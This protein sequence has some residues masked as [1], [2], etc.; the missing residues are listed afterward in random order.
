MWPRTLSTSLA[1]FTLGLAVLSSSGCGGAQAR[2]AKHLQKGR[3][4]LAEG[5]LEKARVELRNALQIA[6]KDADA[7]FEMGVVAE[8]L[9][10]Q[11]E[12]AQYY[13][14]TIDVAPEHIGARAQLARLYLFS[15]APDRA[16]DLIKPV[17]DKHPEE[18]ELLTVR[19]A[20]HV[21]HKDLSA[22]QAD[23]E[24]AVQLASTSENAVAVLAG[25][26]TSQ[27][28]TAKA[29][30]LLERSIQKIPATVD[31]RLV[32]AQIYAQQSRPADA[33]AL[34]IKLVELKPAEKAHRLRLAQ[35]YLQSNQIDAAER[36]MRQAVS[37][38]P[39]DRDLKLSLIDFLAARRS[40]DTAEKELQKMIAAAPKDSVLKFA[41]A[42]FYLEGQDSAH[43]EAVYRGVIESE[44]LDP[45]GLS[46]RD[47]LAALRWQANDVKGALA[48]AEEVLAKSPRDDDAL[49]LRGNIALSKQDPR[50][51]I[52]DLRA[53][54]RDQPNAIGVLRS[55]ARA[56]LANGEPAVAEEVMRHA[57]EANPKNAALE[58]DFAQL[59]AQLGKAEQAKPIVTEMVKQS[60][61]NI[62]ALSTEF[63]I[64]LATKDFVMAKSAADG[65]VAIQP[66]LA[67]GYLYQ[68]TVAEHDGR[69]D[70]ALNLYLKAADLQPDAAEPMEAEV[71]L[72]VR[73]KR[74]AEAVRRLDDVAARFPGNSLALNLKGNLFLSDGRI[75]EARDTFN[76]AIARTP[77]WWPPY[78]GL[79]YAQLA[80]KDSA[81]AITTLRNAKA[82]VSQRDAL[83]QELAGLLERQGKQDEA[84]AE[85]EEIV[86]GYPQS[87][88][89]ANNLAM[90]LA[91]YKK[92]PKSLE[93]AK[94]LSA[95]FADS[96]NPSFLDTYGWVLFKRGDAAASVPVL[97]RVV[98]KVPDAAMARYHLGMAQALAGDNSDARD[99]LTRALNSGTQF[100]GLDEAKS[101]LDKL[102]KIPATASVPKS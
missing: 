36:T 78:R 93:R 34:L 64:G 88:I 79:A 85:Y 99:N 91:T 96:S 30:A 70:E 97:M 65:I 82:V 48:L 90:L 60:P 47:R 22:A 4:F 87:E 31:L 100:S 95:R 73:A 49:I 39:S 45:A 75:A 67:V 29:Q 92:D 12:A 54:L 5:N 51:A 80:A 9:G 89:A 94:E 43:A 53:V 61:D 16:L 14:G 101:T 66:K 13:Q 57:V 86:R 72:L 37:D 28:D 83:G 63:R 59:L 15:G 40:R 26:Y 8:K 2:E 71:R 25:V 24:R 21:Q 23:A 102:T 27:S 38:L 41:L 20:I 33:E 32:L 42:K 52:A 74:T 46:A 17:I 19:A 58:M 62:E 68:G 69:N 55:L 56:H 10:N 84:I 18:A 77:K 98:A 35:F 81:G 1:M 11:R 50:A 6:P 76:V 44:K 7:R 3:A